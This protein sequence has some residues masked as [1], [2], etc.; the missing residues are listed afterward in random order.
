ME[1]IR[2]KF[3]DL[4]DNDDEFNRFLGEKN[5]VLSDT[6]KL[7]DE[8][9]EKLIEEYEKR[10]D[11]KE[12]PEE[13]GESH[14]MK[15]VVVAELDI[16]KD[17][18]DAIRAEA[19]EKH[20]EFLKEG[21]FMRRLVWGSMFKEVSLVRY[22]KAIRKEYEEGTRTLDKS[23]IERFTMA[24]TRSAEDALI[25]DKAGERYSAYSVKSDEDGEYVER[26]YVDE[27]GEMKTERVNKD[28]EMAQN[29]I[30]LRDLVRQYAKGEIDE[31]KFRAEVDAM[32]RSE[33]ENGDRVYSI[34]NYVEAAKAARENIEHGFAIENVMEGFAYIN[35]EARRNVRTE[36][37]RDSLDRITHSLMRSR[38]GRWVPPE[39]IALGT[40][41]AMTFGKSTLSASFAFGG[42]AVSGVLAG[43]KERSRVT[44]E[45][46]VAQRRMAQGGELGDTKYDKQMTETIQEM[47][48]AESITSEFASIMSSLE[49]SELSE[50][51]RK[52][53]QERLLQ[54][55][56][57]AE[58]AVSISDSEGI[59]LIR[60]ANG[61]NATIE[62]QR[63]AMDIMRAQARKMLREQGVTDEQFSKTI[64]AWSSNFRTGNEELEMVG[65]DDKEKAFRKLRRKRVAKKTAIAV[66]MGLATT[67]GVEEARA[68]IDDDIHGIFD[69]LTGHRDNAGASETVLAN[70]FGMHQDSETISTVVQQGIDEATAKQLESE[71]Y[72]ITQA[73]TRTEL[74]TVAVSKNEF[75]EAN[76]ESVTR[77]WLNNDTLAYDGNELGIHV[78]DSGGFET[79][80][81]GF[82]TR[83]GEQVNFDDGNNIVGFLTLNRG[84]APIQIEGEIVNGQ[85]DFSKGLEELGLGNIG[86]EGNYQ[87]FEVGRVTSTA[88][89]GTLNVDVFAT[90]T[91]HGFG[92]DM[93]QTV[94]EREVPIFDAISVTENAG[95]GGI[96]VP[97][98][99]VPPTS[100]RGIT[101]GRRGGTYT[102]ISERR[103]PEPNPEPESRITTGE[104]DGGDT[105]DTSG[106]GGASSGDASGDGSS[107]GDT[108][109][110]TSGDGGGTGDAS[111]DGL[112]L[113]GDTSGDGRSA[114]DTSGDTSGDGDDTSDTSGDGSSAGDASGDGGGAGDTSGDTSGDGGG[115]GDA[116]GDGLALG[117]D[118]SGDGRS[119][120]DTSGDGRSV[121][122]TSGDVKN[123]L[124]RGEFYK[125][126]G[127]SEPI[128]KDSSD[129]SLLYRQASNGSWSMRGLENEVRRYAYEHDRITDE[130]A[131]R[132]YA[133]DIRSSIRAWGSY[134]PETQKAILEGTQAM[135][136]EIKFLEQIGLIKI[137]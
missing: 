18:E 38:I 70:M 76:G 116:S 92:G 2:K 125:Y 115:A 104:G 62:D 17:I 75:L 131:R 27:N 103:R 112:A 52:L 36:E 4:I 15:S 106:D 123:D 126:M 23:G 113:G 79:H 81:S 111:G 74:E 26:R 61:E 60:Y 22:E 85:V 58:A 97:F 5:I 95:S 50:E 35:G 29:T 82:S 11:K 24:Y 94:T 66:G 46:S 135:P 65:L 25:H 129:L 7:S 93:I 9:R 8:E 119:A 14:E 105:G 69:H 21:G 102:P 64:E 91:G 45:R 107:A 133:M 53:N 49:N 56:G 68:A 41:L 63:I 109:G 51:D 117:G 98:A 34:E 101:F 19:A 128:S 42:V 130:V 67:I 31:K 132:K 136:E 137:G 37:H 48:P 100:R 57:M 118:T 30:K 88:T 124:S 122:D 20:T 72:T 78:S 77:R 47:V 96:H 99:V 1:R 39:A 71:G 44:T 55:Y 134:T 86:A 28:N 120:G 32:R 80:M 89:D 121:G 43:A 73:G 83:A 40:S 33:N 6:K 108:S 114:G 110:D 87:W 54:Q 13:E 127:L 16:D 84:D 10:R 3:G 90:S 59:D 12:K